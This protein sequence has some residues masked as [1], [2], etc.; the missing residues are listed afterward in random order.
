MKEEKPLRIPDPSATI[1]DFGP[2]PDLSNA[3]N[4]AKLLGNGADTPDTPPEA[5]RPAP[6]AAPSPRPRPAAPPLSAAGKAGTPQNIEPEEGSNR[7]M[8]FAAVG[9]AIALVAGVAAFGFT[10]VAGLGALFYLQ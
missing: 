7:V 1:P 2:P 4:L 5:N 3:P 9:L 6:A 10:L 8:M